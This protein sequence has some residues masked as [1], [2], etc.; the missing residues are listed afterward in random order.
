MMERS[1]EAAES[2]FSVTAGQMADTMYFV[3]VEGRKGYINARPSKEAIRS[4]RSRKKDI[5]YGK[6]ENKDSRKLATESYYYVLILKNSLESEFPFEPLLRISAD[7]VCNM[8]EKEVD[9][10]FE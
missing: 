10:E 7:C 2:G 4:W 1:I 6:V 8:E 5:T 3:A 9:S